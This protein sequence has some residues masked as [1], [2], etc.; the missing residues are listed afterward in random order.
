VVTRAG[1]WGS[2][3]TA[4]EVRHANNLRTRYAHLSG[5]ARGVRAGVRVDQ[6][7]VIGFV[8]SSGLATG[9]HLH[10]EFLRD[11]SHVNPASARTQD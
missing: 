1:S 3:G 10:Y 9:S 11:G 8:G 4:I 7:Q 6:G 5:I 2:Y